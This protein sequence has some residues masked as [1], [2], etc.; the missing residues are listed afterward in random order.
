MVIG[1]DMSRS[2]SQNRFSVKIISLV[3]EKELLE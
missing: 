2:T 1:W 3:I